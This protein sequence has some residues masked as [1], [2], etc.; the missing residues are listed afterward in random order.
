MIPLTAVLFILALVGFSVGG[1]IF[2][3]VVA[4]AIDFDLQ[5]SVAREFNGKSKSEARQIAWSKAV[6]FEDAKAFFGK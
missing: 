1:F 3:A 6:A 2:F 4:A 5:Y